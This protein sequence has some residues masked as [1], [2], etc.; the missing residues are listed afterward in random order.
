MTQD[1]ATT[2]LMKHAYHALST[3]NFYRASVRRR[4]KRPYSP[5]APRARLL[6]S[7]PRTQRCRYQGRRTLRTPAATTCMGT[8]GIDVTLARCTGIGTKAR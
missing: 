7:D 1:P 8:L 6:G 4:H 2:T 3:G 5:A